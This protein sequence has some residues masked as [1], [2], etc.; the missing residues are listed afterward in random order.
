M[1]RPSILMCLQGSVRPACDPPLISLCL[2]LGYT[3]RWAHAVS[4]WWVDGSVTAIRLMCCRCACRVPSNACHY[5]PPGELLHL[6]P[7]CLGSVLYHCVQP[8]SLTAYVDASAS[9]TVGLGWQCVFHML[10]LC[11][12]LQAMLTSPPSSKATC[13]PHLVAC[14]C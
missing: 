10:L 6:F 1:A 9:S 14:L 12:H 11:I 5:N 8:L 4:A 7:Y 13:C 2:S 3:P